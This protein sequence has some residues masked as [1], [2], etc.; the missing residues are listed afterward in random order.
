MS[1][2][3]CQTCKQEFNS[4]NSK[5]KFCSRTC[6][7]KAN[8]W[9]KPNWRK[10]LGWMNDKHQCHSCWKRINSKPVNCSE[11]KHELYYEK[12]LAEGRKYH[13]DAILYYGGKCACCGFND[14]NK[15]IFGKS[16]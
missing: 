2:H 10:G 5:R 13:I 7:Y 1:N 3:I 11:E 6:F 4:G 8:N 12:H 9:F 15:T 16:F 14:I